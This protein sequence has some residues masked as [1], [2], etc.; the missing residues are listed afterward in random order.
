[1]FMFWYTR[2]QLCIRWGAKIS[3][4]LLFL[5]EYVTEKYY[6]QLSLLY[7]WMIPRY[8]LLNTSRIGCYISDVCIKHVFYADDL[9]L[10]APCAIALQGLLNI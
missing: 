6:L 3:S 4:F 5:M 1:M 10:M 2:Q 7:T 9:W 8:S